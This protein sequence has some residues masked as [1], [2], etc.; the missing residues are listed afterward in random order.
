MLSA[1]ARSQPITGAQADMSEH[2][3]IKRALEW[4]FG[5]EKAQLPDRRD[6]LP[7]R[8]HVR[9]N[10]ARVAEVGRLGC[11]V[12]SAGA[13][14]SFLASNSHADADALASLVDATLSRDDAIMVAAYA[15]SASEP[16]GSAGMGEHHF[17]PA[18]YFG[19]ECEPVE[20]LSVGTTTGWPAGMREAPAG[21][22]GAPRK[23]T[24]M[25]IE[26]H[27][28]NAPSRQA[29]LDAERTRWLAALAKV[30]K[31]AQGMAWQGKQRMA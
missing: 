7:A 11:M 16:L 20:C 26:V 15:R 17:A 19:S 14:A 12:D 6:S 21:K 23:F 25:C 30:A 18:S 2:H 31:A 27:E 3:K 4:A 24:S 13:G 1:L 8:P 5:R 10:A 22:R 28:V 9:S 29:F